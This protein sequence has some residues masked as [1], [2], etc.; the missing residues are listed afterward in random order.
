MIDWDDEIE[1]HRRQ[2]NSRS[3]G[4]RHDVS[5][6]VRVE[7]LRGGDMNATIQD[8]SST[9]MSM[10]LPMS[11][12]E[13]DDKVLPFGSSLSIVF[14]PDHAN[15]PEDVVRLSVVVTRRQL[16]IIGV[17]FIDINQDQRH[18]LRVL[19][20]LAVESRTTSKS[21]ARDTVARPD[22]ELDAR[23]IMI[24]CRKVI[25]QRL[26]NIVWTLRTELVTQLRIMGLND[27]DK[28]EAKAEAELIEQKSTAITRTIERQ[29]LQTFAELSGLDSTQELVF[30]RAQL[31]QAAK[32]M[33]DK[34]VG[35]IDRKS[36]ER[37]IAINT[38]C[39]RLESTLAGKSFDLNVRLANVLGR[40]IEDDQTP[41][42]PSTMCRILWQAVQQYCESPHVDVSLHA[43]IVKRIMPMISELYG[44]LGTTLDKNN[45]PT[46]YW[47]NK[48]TEKP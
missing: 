20:M 44:D 39:K 38:A 27:T 34:K 23:A 2:E 40:R 33:A 18:A 25:E 1:P 24:A 32:Q 6:P 47:L 10:R 28:S 17:R 3:G 42:A 11:A 13:H 41:L 16:P 29:V 30:T 19:A 45:V 21:G 12:T 14:A 35:L 37:S 5:I 48:G 43:V 31:E 8:V 26:P 46:S 36:L 9:G 22:P 7:G 15:A 4:L